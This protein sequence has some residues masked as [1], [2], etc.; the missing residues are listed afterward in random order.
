MDKQLLNKKG[1][2]FS[3][4][5]VLVIIGIS[6]FFSYK[7]QILEKEDEF[8]MERLQL[9]VIDNFVREFDNYYLEHIIDTAAKPALEAKL[10]KSYKT[11]TKFSMEDFEKVMKHGEGILKDE[12]TTDSTYSQTLGTLSFE[13]PTE[14]QNFDYT[15]KSVKQT[16]YDT[17]EMEFEASYSFSVFGS[18]WSKNNKEILITFDLY[19]LRHPAYSGEIITKSWIKGGDD[20]FVSDVFTD[21]KPCSVQNIKPK[22]L[23]E[24]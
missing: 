13:L 5:I 4:L 1:Q 9:V 14:K 2:F 20:C 18:T 6:I 15:L 22:L 12:F 11:F 24:I 19:S 23:D 17:I 8:H 3:I 10:S 21:A 7:V 16:S